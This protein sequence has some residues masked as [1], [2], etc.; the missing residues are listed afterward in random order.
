MTTPPSNRLKVYVDADVMFRAATAIHSRTGTYVLLRLADLTLI[1]AVTSIHTVDEA[2]NALGRYLPDQ[3]PRLLE[4]IGTAIVV[5]EAPPES[6][7]DTYRTH[8]HRKDVV[9]L[10]AAMQAQAHVLATFNTR[11]YTPPPGRIRVMTPGELLVAAR[12]AILAEL[13]LKSS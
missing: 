9:N 11:H 2:V 7:L 10:A 4:L 1:E 5:N 8:A 13:S 6:M 12:L 3:V